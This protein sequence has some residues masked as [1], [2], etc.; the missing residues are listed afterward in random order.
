[1]SMRGV[2]VFIA[3]LSAVLLSSCASTVPINYY[4]IDVV[5]KHYRQYENA[6]ERY[7]T[8]VLLAL[9]SYSSSALNNS[10][11]GDKYAGP[12]TGYKRV[13]AI[14]SGYEKYVRTSKC[15]SPNYQTAASDMELEWFHDVWSSLVDN[16]KATKVNASDFNKFY[17]YYARTLIQKI[18]D[19]SYNRFTP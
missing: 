18:L 9:M 3:L 14:L 6:R 12:V 11:E 19:R 16:A 7:R 2:R 5:N 13:T 8:D 1:M 4:T 17:V 15:L 10:Y